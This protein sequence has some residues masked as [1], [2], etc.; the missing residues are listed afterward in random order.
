MDVDLVELATMVEQGY[1]RKVVHPAGHLELFNYSEKCTYEGIWN[2]TTRQCRGLILDLE[3][4]IVARPFSKFFNWGEPH[5]PDLDLDAP[6]TVTNKLDG[7]LGI[8]YRVDTPSRY[9]GNPIGAAANGVTLGEPEWAIATRGSF[10]SDQAFHA[11][12]LWRERY[13]DWYPPLDVTCLFEIIY[14]GN[15]IVVDYGDTDDL[16]FLGAREIETGADIPIDEVG[17]PGL[18]TGTFHH[19]PTLRAALEAEPRP[20]QEGLVVFFPETGDRV[21]L[22]QDDYVAIHRLV[23]G[24]TARRVWE[25]AGVHDLTALGLAVKQIGIA[26]QMDPVDVQGMIDAAPGGNW[27]DELL[28]IVPEEFAAWAIRTH[29]AIIASV[30]GWEQEARDAMDRLVDEDGISPLE[31][32][33]A[34]L[35]IKQES[36]ELQGALFALLDGKSIRAF[37]WRAVKPEHETYRAEEGE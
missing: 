33:D 19:Y 27:M 30:D 15:R 16:L 7:S 23:F 12:E 1:V 2:D 6:V 21:K 10:T 28:M 37:A 36:K 8:L 9:D 22:K 11:T 13:A 14:P 26:L 35:L 29:D 5:A 31:R 32:K 17:W 20:G 34:A 25:H 4:N 24:L 18:A 3:G